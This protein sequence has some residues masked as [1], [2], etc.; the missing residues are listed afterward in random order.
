MSTQITAAILVVGDEIL[1][2]RTKD[3]NS[4]TIACFLLPFGIALKE[5]RVVGDEPTQIIDALNSLRLN[6]DFVFSTGGIGPTHDDITADCVAAAFGVKIDVRQDA[7]DMMLQRYKSEDLNQARLRM[8]RIP[9]G[10][11]LIKNPI[12]F[13]PGFQIENVFVMAGVPNIMA[14]MLDDI[15]PRLPLGDIVVSKTIRAPKLREGDIADGL[16]GI[17]KAYS[18]LSFG[19]YPWFS[20][21]GHGVQIVVRGHDEAM[22]AKAIEELMAMIIPFG[23][24]PILLD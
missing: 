11:S 8:A 18:M 23:P 15:A 2:G 19:S 6:H 13:A 21:E 24:N 14:S 9:E 1:S 20:A 17:A 12:S 5:I 3:T 22:I 4:H 7:V 10:A 16:G